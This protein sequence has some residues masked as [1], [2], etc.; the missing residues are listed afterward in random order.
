MAL[1][2]SQQQQL[3]VQLVTSHACTSHGT[4]SVRFVPQASLPVNIAEYNCKY[5]LLDII[6]VARISHPEDQVRQISL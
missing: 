6:I 1:E 4:A 2:G 3:H 5:L